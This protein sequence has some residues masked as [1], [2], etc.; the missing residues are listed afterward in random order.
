M[1]LLKSG[2]WMSCGWRRSMAEPS[3]AITSW[4][5][6]SAGGAGAAGRV[7]RAGGHQRARPVV[8]VELDP[9]LVAVGR[10]VR[11]RVPERPGTNDHLDV[12]GLAGLQSRQGGAERDDLAAA[13]DAENVDRERADED[14]LADVVDRLLVVPNGRERRVRR[15][16]EVVMQLAVAVAELRRIDEREVAVAAGLRLRRVV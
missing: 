3:C 10:P 15:R 6:L 12:D 16:E 2:T 4:A 8:C 7:Q 5:S 13:A 11:I 1:K 14:L 9:R